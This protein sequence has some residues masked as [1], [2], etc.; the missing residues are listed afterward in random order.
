[1]LATPRAA[2]LIPREPTLEMV[3]R[4]LGEFDLAVTFAVEPSTAALDERL[5]PGA[6]PIGLDAWLLAAR[7]LA[8]A[9]G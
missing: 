1:M 8:R 6:D 5:E 7:L 3:R 2:T 4:I 9:T